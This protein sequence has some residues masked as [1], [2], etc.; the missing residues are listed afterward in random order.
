L[1]NQETQSLSSG[2]ASVNILQVQFEILLF[3]YDKLFCYLN[4]EEEQQQNVTP[5][6]QKRAVQTLCVLPRR[7]QRR[8]PILEF[9][10][11][12]LA[13]AKYRRI[14]QSHMLTF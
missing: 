2:T 1:E 6:C 12:H 4:A 9:Q 8:T 7:K 13:E 5:V 11:L 10:L 14:A 3:H